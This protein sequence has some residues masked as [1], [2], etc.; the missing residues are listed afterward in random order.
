MAGKVYSSACKV[1]YSLYRCRWFLSWVSLRM[2]LWV[3]FFL[4]VKGWDL[5]LLG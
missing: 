3:Y 2:A 1:V 5:G 4:L